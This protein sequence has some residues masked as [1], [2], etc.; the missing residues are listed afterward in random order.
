MKSILALTLSIL[1]LAGCG[2]TRDKEPL[3]QI[4]LFE[5]KQYLV[6]N[7][8]P[9]V[10]YVINKF[11]DHDVVFLGEHHRI[12][13]HSVLVQEL[14][15]H[16]YENGIYTL[17]TEFACAAQQNMIDSLLNGE[18]YDESLARHIQTRLGPFASWVSTAIW[19]GRR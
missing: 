7:Q 1:L 15:P 5:L 10:D 19:I 16:L 3:D 2:P 17:A 18:A 8:L 14:V 4:G 9:P 11:V 13:D 6:A 12:K